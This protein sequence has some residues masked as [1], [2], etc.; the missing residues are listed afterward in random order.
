[1]ILFIAGSIYLP[2]LFVKP[3]YNFLYTVYDYSPYNKYRY[4]V[5]D[6]RIVR[7]EVQRPKSQRQ[8]PQVEAKL[9]IYDVKENES[10]KIPFEEARELKLDPT[11]ESPDGFEVVRGSGT[12]EFFP[13][14][15]AEGDRKAVYLRGHNIRRKLNVRYRGSFRFLGWIIE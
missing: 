14:F 6:G 9:Y 13:F 12:A 10:R 7:E 3:K 4:Y 15:W 8:R 1:M 5:I 11:P 2:A